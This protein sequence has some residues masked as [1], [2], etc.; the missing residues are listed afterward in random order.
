MI[1]TIIIGIVLFGYAFFVIRKKVR[2]AKNGKFCD[3]GCGGCSAKCHEVKEERE[4]I[5]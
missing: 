1:A 4:E 5:I 3:C 2:D